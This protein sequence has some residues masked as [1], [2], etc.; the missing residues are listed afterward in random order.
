VP[1]TWGNNLKGK[2]YGI[3]AWGDLRVARWWTLSGGATV[4]KRT[5]DFKPGAFGILGTSQLG[6]D[7]PYVIK[8]HSA[9][10][11][12][13]DLT[14]DLDVRAYGA[15]RQSAV[16]AYE[17]LGARIAWQA[18]PKVTLSVQGTNLLPGRH[19]EYP[20]GDLLPGRVLGGVDLRF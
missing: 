11:P 1:L 9:M 18:T 2:T 8:L 19:Q 20:Q 12:V 14:I 7:P 5:F 15:L 10:N 16:P 4:L 13:H 3:E 6:N 17:E